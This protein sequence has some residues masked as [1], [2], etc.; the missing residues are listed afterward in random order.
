MS[1]FDITG[2]FV[3]GLAEPAVK[4]AGFPPYNFVG[5]HN[6]PERIPDRGSDRRDGDGAAAGRCCAGDV[7]PGARAAGLFRV[8]RVRRRKSNERRGMQISADDVLITTGSGQGIDI[9]SRLLLNAGDTVLLEEFCYAGAINRFRKLGAKL[10]ALPVDED[11][12]RTDELGRILKEQ[13]AT[14][15]TPKFL[16]TIPTIQNPTGSILPLERR[17]RTAAAAP[18]VRRARCSRTNATPICCGTT[19]MRRLRLSRWR[20]TR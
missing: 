3:S 7:Q 18:P 12:I 16:Y 17:Q 4:F 20:R 10:V 15:V 13:K 11:G 19:W 6:D 9:V 5:G 2:R 8:A 1:E 14:G